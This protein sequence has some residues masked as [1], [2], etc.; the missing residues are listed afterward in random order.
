MAHI[1]PEIMHH[2]MNKHGLGFL[3]ITGSKVAKHLPFYALDLV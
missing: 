3:E 1:D 2:R